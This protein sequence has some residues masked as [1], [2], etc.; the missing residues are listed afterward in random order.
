MKICVRRSA[1]VTKF[2]SKLANPAGSHVRAGLESVLQTPPLQ[3]LLASGTCGVI[4]QGSLPDHSLPST[5]FLAFNRSVEHL[6]TIARALT[7][8]HSAA[9]TALQLACQIRSV[10]PLM[11]ILVC[12][13]MMSSG[14][15][16]PSAP[17][18]LL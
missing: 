10:S 2:V 1:L 17:E 4:G 15:L 11:I 18:Q 16:D 5:A 6:G 14:I 12:F 8:A 3:C 7:E 13:P 9:L